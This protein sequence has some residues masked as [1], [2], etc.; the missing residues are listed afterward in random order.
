[1]L[2]FIAKGAAMPHCRLYF[3]NARNGHIDR[4]NDIQ[5]SNDEAA[6]E[7]AQS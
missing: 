1:V 3:M 5:A 2:P 6:I 7:M 4:V